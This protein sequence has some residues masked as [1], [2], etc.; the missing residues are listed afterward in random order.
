[1]RLV[2]SRGLA[3]FPC[4]TNEIALEQ[5]LQ[6][7]ITEVVSCAF[8]SL[9]L[10]DCAFEPAL[11]WMKACFMAQAVGTYAGHIRTRRKPHRVEFAAGSYRGNALLAHLGAA[12]PGHLLSELGANV[13]RKEERL[14]R[15]VE[16]E[17]SVVAG[18]AG[19]HTGAVAEG[20][21]HDASAGAGP[22]PE[23]KMTIAWPVVGGE[24][25]GA[26][27]V[28]DRG[29]GTRRAAIRPPASPPGAAAMAPVTSG[30]TCE[31]PS[32]HAT[33]RELLEKY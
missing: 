23:R 15:S 10:Q 3:F 2:K 4:A 29:D 8:A 28:P 11:D 25:D 6:S 17:A 13:D 31:P 27:R 21:T 30:S 26:L 5:G 20:S 32:K 18:G 22:L 7:L 1:M 12:F 19:Y 24:G 9:R 33:K 14:E 16:A